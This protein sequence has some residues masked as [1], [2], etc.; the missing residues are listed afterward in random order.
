MWRIKGNGGK[1]FEIKPR[2]RTVPCLSTVF[3][4]VDWK[5]NEVGAFD[6]YFVRPANIAGTI[7]TLYFTGGALTPVFYQLL[8]RSA[9]MGIA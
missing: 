1:M 3:Q 9:Q 8:E 7:V 4:E 6:H 2:H 5:N